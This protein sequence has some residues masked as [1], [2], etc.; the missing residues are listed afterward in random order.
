MKAVTMNDLMFARGVLGSAEKVNE[1]TLHIINKP[2]GIRFLEKSLPDMTEIANRKTTFRLP[3]FVTKCQRQ[4]GEEGSVPT[5]YISWF[6]EY[7]PTFLFEFQLYESSPYLSMTF[8]MHQRKNR[9]FYEF[10]PG[11][12][13]MIPTKDSAQEAQLLGKQLK[14]IFLESNMFRLKYATGMIS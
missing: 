2:F 10:R 11:T 13:N 4:N 3:L 14:E 8:R 12:V 5:Y 1:D 7:D 6:S 9:S